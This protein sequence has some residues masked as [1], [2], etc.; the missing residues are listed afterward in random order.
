MARRGGEHERA[1]GA[2]HQPLLAHPRSLTDKARALQ[3]ASI[4]LLRSPSY[5]HPFY[6]TS[7]IMVGDGF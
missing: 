6:W 1:D 3:A 4:A 2:F 5:Q 7:F